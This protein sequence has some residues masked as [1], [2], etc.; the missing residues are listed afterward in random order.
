VKV[1]TSELQGKQLDWAVA[2]A[3]GR[4][5]FFGHGLGAKFAYYPSKK[6][7]DGGKIIDREQIMF[8]AGPDKAVMA[9]LR[10]TGYAMAG[11]SWA[12]PTHLIAACRC[13]CY[14]KLGGEIDIPEE[15]CQPQKIY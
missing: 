8:H 14:A 10:R 13:F 7:A 4:E 15:L 12:G 5:E 1:K 6:W 3:E 2:K 9:Y 11:C